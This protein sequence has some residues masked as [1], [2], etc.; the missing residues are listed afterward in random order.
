MFGEY[1]LYS[2]SKI[3]ALIYDNQLFIKQT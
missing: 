3:M 2:N 1:T